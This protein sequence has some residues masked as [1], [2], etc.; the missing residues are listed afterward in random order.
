MTLQK[1]SLQS[2][3]PEFKDT[4]CLSCCNLGFCKIQCPTDEKTWLNCAH[5]RDR[6][7]LEFAKRVMAL[8]R[9]GRIHWVRR[10]V[11][12]WDGEKRLI[13]V[14]P[15]N[16]SKKKGFIGRN[17]EFISEVNGVLRFTGQIME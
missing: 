4:V 3:Q 5:Y 17:F 14:L 9:Q 7:E 6:Q 8:E 10:E 11:E 16:T 1:D 12:M 15:V 13:S 2:A